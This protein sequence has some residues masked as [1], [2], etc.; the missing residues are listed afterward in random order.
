VSKNATYAK[1]KEITMKE[2]LLARM[3]KLNYFMDV[4]PV[5]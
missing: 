1:S 3:Q 2:I 4:R 5:F